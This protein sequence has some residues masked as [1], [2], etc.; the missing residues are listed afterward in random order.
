VGQWQGVQNMQIVYPA[1]YAT[2]RPLG[3]S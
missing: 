2:A 3:M 1:A